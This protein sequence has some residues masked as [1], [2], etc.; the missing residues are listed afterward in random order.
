[1]SE[2]F[3]AAKLQRNTTAPTLTYVAQERAAADPCDDAAEEASDLAAHS[4]PPRSRSA[5]GR[6]AS[7]SEIGRAAFQHQAA[8]FVLAGAAVRK[9][10][11]E[12][13]RKPHNISLRLLVPSMEC[14]R[15]V[16]QWHHLSRRGLL[17]PFERSP[18]EP[19]RAKGRVAEVMGANDTQM[20]S[21]V[22]YFDSR[23]SV[24]PLLFSLT[25]RS[26]PIFLLAASSLEKDMWVAGI[27]ALLSD[28]ATL[29]ELLFDAVAGFERLPHHLK[30]SVQTMKGNGPT[31][32]QPL[33][34][35]RT[36]YVPEHAQ[37]AGRAVVNGV[38]AVAAGLVSF[39]W[40]KTRSVS[41]SSVTTVTLQQHVEGVDGDPD[42]LVDRSY[43]LHASAAAWRNTSGPVRLLVAFH[44]LGE[45]ASTWVD[46]L[47]PFVARGD[48]VG[49]YPEGLRKN[50]GPSSWNC[51][52]EPSNADDVAFVDVVLASLRSQGLQVDAASC[53]A[54]GYSNGGA[55]VMRLACERAH[56]GRVAT[57]VTALNTT[58]RPSSAASLPGL[59]VLQV[60][61]M[62]DRLIPYQGGASR[63][64]HT[65]L[66]GKASA[67]TWAEFACGGGAPT[68]ARASSGSERLEWRDDA[69]G[70][71]VTHIGIADGIHRI[72]DQ[73]VDAELG[74]GGLYPVVV[75]F[76]FGLT[77]PSRGPSPSSLE[78]ATE[79]PPARP[80]HFGRRAPS[81]SSP[82]STPMTSASSPPTHSAGPATPL[83]PL[84]LPPVSRLS[85][86]ALPPPM[87]VAE[88]RGWLE[89]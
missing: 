52:P 11:Q 4:A 3:L 72:H 42:G 7:E 59:S 79:F 53:S 67:Q 47:Q 34:R 61:G 31:Y 89:Y 18:E 40:G 60:M 9:F 35:E 1:M 63:V 14:H 16:L 75:A 26:R 68:V 46:A 43:L 25:L 62:K 27:N 84:A 8:R 65:F 88:G 66:A 54:L 48:F 45:A 82:S 37:H 50:G 21:D 10:G 5:G 58:Q 24:K 2:T 80:F 28:E 30:L 83:S 13:R 81:S 51:G 77:G 12:G 32:E 19:L 73:C 56:F 87:P 39:R 44:G 6:F 71:C 78:L 22:T 85:P 49:V 20:P 33:K 69:S 41:S 23:L 17:A 64:G 29:S 15:R 38:A 57:V 74:L 86:V 36:R 55:L 70:A 76:L